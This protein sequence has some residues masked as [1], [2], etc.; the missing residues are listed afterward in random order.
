MFLHSDRI[1]NAHNEGTGTV[2]RVKDVPINGP[3]VIR[4]PAFQVVAPGLFAGDTERFPHGGNEGLVGHLQRLG[5]FYA[6]CRVSL[7]EYDS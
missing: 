7:I 6:P 1:N 3:A 5:E 2:P 4:H